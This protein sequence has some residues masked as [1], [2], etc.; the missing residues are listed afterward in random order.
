MP[1]MNDERIN[2]GVSRQED[3]SLFAETIGKTLDITRW[4][5]HGQTRL[6]VVPCIH[7]LDID[8]IT[9]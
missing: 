2:A 1:R 4:M 3:L 9:L 7:F 6:M 5:I 8:R